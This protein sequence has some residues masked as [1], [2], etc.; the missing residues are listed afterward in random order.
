MSE[1]AFRFWVE[2]VG[3]IA[4]AVVLAGYL[5]FLFRPR[6]MPLAG[7]DGWESVLPRADFTTAA[8]DD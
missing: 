1:Q 5:R 2:I 4:V 3:V 7:D 8:N 6:R